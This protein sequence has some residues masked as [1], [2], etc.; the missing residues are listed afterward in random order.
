MVLFAAWLLGIVEMYL[1][2]E[3]KMGAIAG[4][5]PNRFWVLMHA[6][7]NAF[8]LNIGAVLAKSEINRQAVPYLLA[9]FVITFVSI[10][11]IEAITYLAAVSQGG[12]R[13]RFWNQLEI[14]NYYLTPVFALFFVFFI[15]NR[16]GMW[17]FLLDV[18]MYVFYGLYLLFVVIF[19]GVILQMN[20]KKIEVLHCMDRTEFPNVVC[21]AGCAL[22]YLIWT[23]VLVLFLLADVLPAAASLY[24]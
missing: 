15:V 18:G 21:M 5:A 20:N 22:G 6:F 23:V 12:K 1:R 3:K 24:G 4:R 2:P 14:T 16:I 7:A 17:L 11:A 8:I 9:L 10:V 19:F 13:G